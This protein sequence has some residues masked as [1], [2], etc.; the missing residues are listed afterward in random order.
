MTKKKSTRFLGAPLKKSFG[1]LMKV[2][3]RLLSNGFLNLELT[4]A[5]FAADT[6]IPKENMWN[7][8]IERN[9]KRCCKEKMQ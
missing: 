6:E 9:S 1:P 2:I 7:R 8:Y 4:A 3:V 5:S